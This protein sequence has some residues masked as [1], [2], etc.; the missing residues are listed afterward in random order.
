[1]GIRIVVLISYKSSRYALFFYYYRL[2]NW[3]YFMGTSKNPLWAFSKNG[4]ARRCKAVLY[5]TL[6]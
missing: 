1:M 5:K 2:D 3:Y 6:S 4:L